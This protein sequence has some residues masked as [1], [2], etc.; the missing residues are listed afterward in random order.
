MWQSKDTVAEPPATNWLIPN[1]KIPGRFHI[2]F[3]HF[4]SSHWGLVNKGKSAASF[5]C[6][7]AEWVPD[8][9]R[10]FYLVKNHKTDK[11]STAT[12]AIEK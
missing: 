8:M 12:K 11:N 6:Q 3:N 10:N 9:F 2:L 4:I 7:V 1:G 5:C